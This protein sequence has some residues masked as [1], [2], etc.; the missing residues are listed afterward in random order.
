MRHALAP[1]FGDPDYFSIED[2]YATQ[3]WWTGWAQAR[4]IGAKLQPR[5]SNFH[6]LFVTGVVASKPHS[7]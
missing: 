2:L 4:E 3:S 1:G 6:N 5:I 7:S